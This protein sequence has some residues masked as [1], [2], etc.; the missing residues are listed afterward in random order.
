MNAGGAGRMHDRGGMR[1][2][3]LRQ[4]VPGI[5]PKMLTQTLGQ[6]ERNGLVS[7]KVHAVIP[8]Q[9]EY[10]RT[11]LGHW[12]GPVIHGLWTGVEQNSTGL[13]AARKE[14]DGQA[15]RVAEQTP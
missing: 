11:A 1:C 9:V 3:E 10:L 14:F 15:A 6:M 7:R 4:A 2:N 5:S 8:P 13:V 12:L